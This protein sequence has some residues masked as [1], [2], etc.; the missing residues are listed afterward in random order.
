MPWLQKGKLENIKVNQV[1]LTKS[2]NISNLGAQLISPI[3]KGG[4]TLAHVLLLFAPVEVL[5]Q[6]VGHVVLSLPHD[7][8]QLSVSDLLLY[9]QYAHLHLSKS[10]N[11]SS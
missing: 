4:S 2:L 7:D 6:A 10:P 3:A 8:G 1:N 9:R 11:T 5:G